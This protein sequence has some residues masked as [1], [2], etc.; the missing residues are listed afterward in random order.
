MTEKFRIENGLLLSDDQTIVRFTDG[1]T[2]EHSLIPGAHEA[3]EVVPCPDCT[4]EHRIAGALVIP[5]AHNI[6]IT[7]AEP[8]PA[9]EPDA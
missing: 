4:S 1:C 8:A 6:T 2:D 9:A 3:G 7:Q 5:T